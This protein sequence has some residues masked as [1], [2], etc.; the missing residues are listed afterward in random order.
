MHSYLRERQNDVAVVL[1]TKVHHVLA[2]VVGELRGT[3]VVNT[4]V[5]TTDLQ[6]DALT[7]FKL[8]A[9]RPDTDL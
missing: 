6:P 8:N 2:L 5:L 9:S 1:A 7:S 3:K 4:L